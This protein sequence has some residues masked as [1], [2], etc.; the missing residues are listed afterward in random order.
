MPEP[1]QEIDAELQA[2][3][4]KEDPQFQEVDLIYEATA[5][6]GKALTGFRHD[7]GVR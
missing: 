1:F 3:Q 4:Q 7:E 6:L 5:D 2:K